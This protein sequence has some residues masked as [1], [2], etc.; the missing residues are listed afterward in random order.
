MIDHLL[1]RPSTRLKRVQV[2]IVLAF[3]GAILRTGPKEGHRQ[4]PYVRRLN[5]WAS[6]CDGLEGTQ[7]E[8]CREKH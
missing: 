7:A 8:P 1:G 2:L 3:W 6:A 4:I 5:A